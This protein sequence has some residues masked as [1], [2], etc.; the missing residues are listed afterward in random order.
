MV[1][2]EEAADGRGALTD[3]VQEV[4]GIADLVRPKHQFLKTERDRVSSSAQ[5]VDSLK[6]GHS[7]RSRNIRRRNHKKLKMQVS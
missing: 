6:Y 3:D 5:A 4:L 2:K 1:R 7:A